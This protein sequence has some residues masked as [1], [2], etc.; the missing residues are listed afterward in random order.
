MSLLGDARPGSVAAGVR[1]V[2]RDHV[3]LGLSLLIGITIFVSLFTTLFTS[4]RGLTTSTIATNGTLLYWL[5]QH[6]VRRGEQ[7]WFYFLTL[8]PQYEYIALFF[9]VGGHWRS[10]F[11]P[12]G[13]RWDA[14]HPVRICSS[15][16]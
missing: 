2:W 11:A 16:A 7:P 5:G 12:S 3:G 6:D 14:G 10:A 13:R 4:L 15:A 8:A 1:A 9:G